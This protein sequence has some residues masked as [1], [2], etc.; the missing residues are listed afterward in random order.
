[1]QS[2]Q[3]PASLDTT[4]FTR[5]TGSRVQAGKVVSPDTVEIGDPFRLIV[6]VVVPS[7]ARVEWPT[8]TDTTAVV[9]MREPVKVIDQGGMT[10]GRRERAEYTLSAWDIGAL[11]IGLGDAVV[12]YGNVTMRVPLADA[13]V[14]VKS[15]LPGD[16]T[17]H[18]PKPA[19][20][21]FPR[22][23]PW[24]ERWWPAL[25]VLAALG[26]LWWLWRRRRRHGAE[27]VAAPP[28]DPY[29]RAVHEFERLDRLALAEAGESGR[30]VAL[31]LDVLR[32]YVSARIPEATLSLTSAELLGAVA[33]DP[34]VPRDRLVSL[35]ADADGI[36]FAARRVST[37]RAREIG[38]E[39]RAIVDHIERT[40]R[41][42]RVAEEAARAAAAAAVERE[43]KDAE[44]QAR[45]ASRRPRAGA[46]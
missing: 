41:E 42:R 14:Q 40:D 27:R 20:D 2:V 25:L 15:V 10:G 12:R 36:K 43:R 3:P 31:A 38:A 6:T 26:L 37:P 11:P 19:R 5:Q 16:T 17:L 22:V 39:A 45:R 30:H 28:T 4:L 35:L 46:R 18:V 8:I 44:E 33:D 34:R 9:V 29:A 24:W 21:L 23:D 13:R 32:L 1:M 7:D